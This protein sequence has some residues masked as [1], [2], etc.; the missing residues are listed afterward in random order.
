MEKAADSTIDGWG[1]PDIRYDV[2][3]IR[4]GYVAFGGRRSGRD[5]LVLSVTGA[6][7]LVSSRNR[8]AILKSTRAA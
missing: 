8:Y 5:D 6:R 3:N 4:I 1:E 7:G 2:L